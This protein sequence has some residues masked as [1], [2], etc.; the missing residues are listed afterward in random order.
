MMN[1]EFEPWADEAERLL[2]LIHTQA[3]QDGL[4]EKDVE[5]VLR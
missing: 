1:E 3:I 2:S 4:E 5:R